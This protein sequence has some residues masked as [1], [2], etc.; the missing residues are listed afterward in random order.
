MHDAYTAPYPKSTLHFKRVAGEVRLEPLNLGILMGYSSPQDITLLIQLCQGELGLENS[1]QTGGAAGLPWLNPQQTRKL[2][3]KS[4]IPQGAALIERLTAQF[5]AFDAPLPRQKPSHTLAGL[6]KHSPHA[7]LTLAWE[8][9]RFYLI[10][11]LMNHAA[12]PAFYVM[13]FWLLAFCLVGLPV[14]LKFSVWRKGDT[15]G[16][17]SQE[18][19]KSLDKRKQSP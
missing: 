3:L 2:I 10:K 8:A 9:T 16:L 7:S 5:S 17:F 18:K 4:R 11:I 12:H 19:T 1:P 14:C 13:A 6:V 15:S